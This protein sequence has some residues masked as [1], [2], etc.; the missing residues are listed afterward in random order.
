MDAIKRLTLLQESLSEKEQSL[1]ALG[2]EHMT[3]RLKK[4]RLLE[5]DFGFGDLPSLKLTL[6]KMLVAMQQ[7]E[8]NIKELTIAN[9][10]IERL[11]LSIHRN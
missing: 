5:E 1:D 8:K 10:R 11:P 4:A 6:G 2:A 7:T 9:V 3:A